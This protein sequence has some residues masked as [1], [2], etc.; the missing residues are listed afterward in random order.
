[1]KY[2]VLLTVLCIINTTVYA[3][4]QNKD[5]IKIKENKKKIY[6]NEEDNYIKEWFNSEIESMELSEKVKLEYYDILLKY[7]DSMSQYGKENKV[8]NKEEV[9][10]GLNTI[11]D[12]M[13]SKLKPLLTESQYQQHVNNFKTILWNISLRKGWEY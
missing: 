9:K 13:N 5:S 2:L 8:F 1:M 12:K 4:H 7:T 3:Q 10:T 11:V 6:S